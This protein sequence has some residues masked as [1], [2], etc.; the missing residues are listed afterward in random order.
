M[1]INLNLA[2]HQS[3]HE[4]YALYWA[5]PVMLWALAAFMYLAGSALRNMREY[6]QVHRSVAECQAQQNLLRGRETAALRRLQQPQFQ[7]ILRQANYVNSLID[8]RQLSLT[9]LTGKLTRLLLADVRLT[10]LSLS[11]GSEGPIVRMTIESSDQQKVIAFVQNLEESPDFSDPVISSEDP[12][13]EGG[14]GASVGVA[15][16]IC[17]ARYGGWQSPATADRQRE[18][19]QKSEV[20]SQ[21]PEVRSK[22]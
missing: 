20:R 1:R 7:R 15:R 3:A 21:K 11:Q 13:Q 2:V 8:Q 5:A 16:V 18:R 9:G 12:G 22:K 4:R 19:S 10:T 6:H 14:G 17:T